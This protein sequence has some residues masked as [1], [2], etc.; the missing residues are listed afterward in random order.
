MVSTMDKIRKHKHETKIIK[1][2]LKIN[3]NLRLQSK[4]KLY[5]KF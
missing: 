2:N 4:N 1:K 3:S 5:L